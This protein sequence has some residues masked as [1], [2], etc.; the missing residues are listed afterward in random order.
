VHKALGGNLRFLISGGA[1]LKPS[2]ARAFFSLGLPLLQGWGMTEASPVIAVQRF[3]ASR[4]R[5]SRY[6]EKRA[7][8]VGPPVPGVEVRLIDV[9]EKDIKVAAHGEGEV[10]VRGENVF[11]GY[12]RAE[13]QTRA[14]KMG[15]WL[16]T[17]DVGRI[18]GDGDIYLTGR[19]KYIIVLDSGE[20]VHPDEVEEK[21]SESAVIEDVTVLGRTARDKVQVA[22]IVYPNVD[23]TLAL[24]DREGLQPSEDAVRRLVGAEVDRL[25]RDLAPYKR[26]SQ[27]LIADTPLPKTPLRKVARE[28]LQPDY[29]F[30]LDRWRKTAGAESN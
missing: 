18:D 4:F 5:F 1:A 14:A 3:S 22:A 9:P 24:L 6:Y 30:S 23:A 20:K 8:S 16:R 28:Q 25:V 12:W 13:E 7:G 11:Q 27:L 26:I 21:L 2:T 15:E 29:D 17:G 10:L 19:S